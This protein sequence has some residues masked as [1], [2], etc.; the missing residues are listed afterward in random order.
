M[1]VAEAEAER[2]AAVTRATRAVAATEAAREQVAA[3]TLELK[4]S[5]AVQAAQ[6]AMGA[7]GVG[8]S[9]RGELRVVRARPDT[10]LVR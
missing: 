3:L 4:R 5:Q 2:D 1:Q 10:M 6:A 8:E 7:A 9:P